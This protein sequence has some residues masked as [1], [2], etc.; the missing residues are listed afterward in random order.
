V[1][2]NG[3]CSAVLLRFPLVVELRSGWK[4]LVGSVS[5]RCL[6]R[7]LSLLQ[8]HCVVIYFAYMRLWSSSHY[9]LVEMGMQWLEYGIGIVVKVEWNTSVASVTIIY[10][11]C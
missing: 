7:V 1:C 4:R 2:L 11:A 5:I 10:L 6:C 9:I 3:R 8:C